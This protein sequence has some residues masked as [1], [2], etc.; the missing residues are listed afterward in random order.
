MKKD[1]EELLLDAVI[2]V[3]NKTLDEVLNLISNGIAYRE[4]EVDNDSHGESMR[5]LF[6]EQIPLLRDIYNTVNE[7]KWEGEKKN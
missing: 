4:K 6:Q 3:R 2:D 5:Q 7:L 1:A